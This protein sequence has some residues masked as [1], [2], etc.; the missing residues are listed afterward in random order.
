MLDF[1]GRQTLRILLLTDSEAAGT[2]PYLFT[3]VRHTNCFYTKQ[4]V[5]PICIV[6]DR[7]GDEVVKNF[8][9]ISET[10]GGG[11]REMGKNQIE[12]NV[13]KVAHLEARAKKERTTG[14]KIAEYIANFCGSM[15]FV[16]IH[17]VW[18]GGWIVLNSFSQWTFDPFPFT[19]LTLCV[20]LEAIFLSTFILIS[21]NNETRLTERRNYLDLQVNMLAEQESTKTLE[22]LQRIARKVGIDADDAESKE[23]LEPTNPEELLEKIK[24]AVEGDV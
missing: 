17:L 7:S 15:A 8:Q 2:N 14:E 11:R 3:S 16:Y 24:E 19:F 23:L 20:S 1:H 4:T 22:L 21:Q 13:W 18:F 10:S 6:S 12:S 9:E 5:V